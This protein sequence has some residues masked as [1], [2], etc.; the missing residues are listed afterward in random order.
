MAGMSF[1]PSDSSANGAGV[2]R[3]RLFTSIRSQPLLL[4]SLKDSTGTFGVICGLAA[5]ER[6]LGLTSQFAAPL[7]ELRTALAILDRVDIAA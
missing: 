4:L 6:S 3:G 7:K 5:S 1:G 2:G